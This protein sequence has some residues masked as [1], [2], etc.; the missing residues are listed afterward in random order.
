M[1]SSQQLKNLLEQYKFDYEIT[2]EYLEEDRIELAKLEAKIS[3]LKW[4]IGDEYE[5]RKSN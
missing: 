4:I 1:K 2:K 3:I 5:I